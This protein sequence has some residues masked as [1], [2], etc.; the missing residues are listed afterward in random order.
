[1][2]LVDAGMVPATL[3]V[4]T[5]RSPAIPVAAEDD[6]KRYKRAATPG[7]TAVW[8]DAGAQACSEM[9]TLY[10]FDHKAGLHRQRF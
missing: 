7:S 10:R 2:R 5:V 4:S 3:P 9:M 6:R 8:P 1:L